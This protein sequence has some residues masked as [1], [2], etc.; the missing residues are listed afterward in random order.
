ME[1]SAY[2][3]AAQETSD[4]AGILLQIPDRFFRA[5][6]G[7]E[8][9]RPGRY[10][11]AVCFLPTDDRRRAELEDLLVGALAGRGQRVLGWRHVPVRRCCQ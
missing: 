10:A 9:P 4:G 2:Q 8:L 6:V 1:F 5:V 11:V 7:F 3:R